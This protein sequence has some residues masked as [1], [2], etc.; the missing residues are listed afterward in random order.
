MSITQNK[1]N[2]EVW[3]GSTFG[4]TVT[5][6]DSSGA[7]QNLANYSARMQIRQNYD[8]GSVTESLSTANGEIV[9]TAAEGNVALEL[10]AS[11][12][13]NIF[14]DLTSTSRPPKTTY[15][16]DVE[17]IAANNTVSKLLWGDFTVYGEVTR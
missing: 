5:V 7:V 2:I 17:L 12:T 16:Y 13:A 14:V 10:A 4:L 8:S 3:Q 6:Q 1:Y 9:I 11:R 15:V